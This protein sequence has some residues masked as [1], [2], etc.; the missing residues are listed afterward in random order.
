MT[1]TTIQSKR[2]LPLVTSFIGGVLLLALFFSI[3]QSAQASS[4]HPVAPAQPAAPLETDLGI[5]VQAAT[6]AARPGEIFS[7]TIVYSNTTAHP[8]S[9]VAITATISS[10]QIWD[11]S[12]QAT[13]PL[14]NFQSSGDPD[15]GYTLAWQ[16]GTLNAGAQ[17]SIIFNVQVVTNT[18][19]SSN[20]SIIFL[21]TTAIVTSTQSNVT[22]AQAD[23]VV[24]MVGPLLEITKAANPQKVRPGHLA[25][26]TMTVENIA[27]TDSIP[28]TN[29]VISDVLPEYTTFYNASDNGYYTPTLGTVRWEWEGPLDPGA[30]KIL[31]FSVHLKPDAPL[32]TDIRNRRSEYFVTSEELLFGPLQGEKD[33]NIR[34]I[35]LFEK[36]AVSADTSNGTPR[37]YPD[38]F[39]TYTLTVYNPLS[40]TLEDV[41]VTDTLPGEPVPFTYIRP[42]SGSLPPEGITPDGRA[43]TWTV[44]LPPW[45]WITRSFVV[46]IPREVE[47][48]RNR[49]ETT[50]R[51]T[52]NAFHPDATFREAP[53]LAPVK[54][55]AAVTMDKVASMSH[56]MDGGTVVYTITLTS[57]VDFSVT[58]ITLTD[59]LEGQFR[60]IRMIEGPAPLPEHRS[61][62]IV[63]QGLSLMPQGSMEIAFEARVKGDWLV[64]Y[65]NSLDAHSPDVFIPSRYRIAPV[66]V[67]PP[68]GINK[69]VTPQEV[70]IGD[71][72][73][74]VITITNLSTV[75]FTLADYVRDTL[76]TGFYQVG[77][78]NPGGNPAIINIPTPVTLL[79]DESWFGN[80]TALVSM[81]YGCE[82]LPKTVKNAPGNIVAHVTSP[83]DVLVTNAQGLAPLTISPN[84]LVDL[85]TPHHKV[86]R[87]EIFTYTLHLLNIS[88]TSANNS[89][90]EV[91]LPDG[92][93][94]LQTIS[95]TPPN[96]SGQTLAWNDLTI[97]A[98]SE[99]KVVF[100]VNVE[101]DATF[102]DKRPTFSG[103]AYGV[104]FGRPGGG[105]LQDDGKVTVV[106]HALVL[107][108]KA[109]NSEVPPLAQVD[110][111]IWLE[112]KLDYQYTIQ[113][114]TDTLP[115]GFTYFMVLG[116]TPEPTTINS[117]RIVWKNISIPP[118]KT[119][120]MLRLQASPLY[121][122]FDNTLD[123]Y[124]DALR[125]VAVD[126]DRNPRD[127]N[128]DAIV[129]VGPIFDLSKVV[130]PQYALPGQTVVYTITMVNQSDVNYS[131]IRI[132]DTLPGGFAYYRTLE[133]PTP[134]SIGDNQGTII[135]N[136]LTIKGNCPPTNMGNCTTNI[137]VEV[138]VS[139]S[140][141]DGVHYN[142]I[143]GHSPSGSI[144]GPVETAPV[145]V[146]QT[147]GYDIFLPIILK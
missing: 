102:K 123:G 124:I 81:D 92:I 110:Y 58:N 135:W 126:T 7:Y 125:T 94:Y 38:A 147:L 91:E 114:L 47:I 120:W 34:I 49:T 60:Y 57:H 16:V 43:L 46:Q 145:T 131:A 85:E 44:D 134:T 95:G 74:Y 56:I 40:T 30:S 31:T 97:P 141:A 21:G 20:K 3:M 67:D 17:G 36:S 84:I 62:P 9:D 112:N 104:C 13:P 90:V 75:P 137:V 105:P 55:A 140:T 8:I 128:S 25:V 129:T 88:P 96:V 45:G 116:D 117:S 106:E 133:G 4:A 87:G 86:L 68:L 63:W 15:N 50:Y 10:K 136:N 66:R 98:N 35:P 70:F 82:R 118:G 79:P 72:A 1:T 83:L 41:V 101:T 32:N 5:S 27:R 100:Q 14:S 71:N 19:P 144:P 23:D 103:D 130:T 37:V 22:G 138:Y 42:A 99:V 127:G 111:E 73:D 28:A 52:L 139:H 39:I 48:P 78:D 119:K 59:T 11:G 61:N 122:S 93:H 80:F 64:T 2:I 77:G 142:T 69:S 24:T 146:T 18:E 33:V 65:R 54:V 29:L 89:N 108:K 26:Y 53:N 107:Y 132:T 113:G 109:I 115:D 12:Y 76:P 143:E 6:Q 121:G 51:N